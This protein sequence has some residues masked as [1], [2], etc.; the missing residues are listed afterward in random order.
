[1]EEIEAVVREIQREEDA[2]EITENAM[3][4]VPSV[5]LKD[6][7]LPPPGRVTEERSFP[8]VGFEVLTLSN[9]MKVGM[10]TTD[11]LDDQVLVR[12]FAK[13]GLSEVRRASTSTRCTR[14]RSRPSS[15]FSG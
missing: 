13:G 12:C 8:S 5:V 3:F 9:G 7:A 1:M 4:Q 11:F 2:G 14:T 10:K 15:G 6:E